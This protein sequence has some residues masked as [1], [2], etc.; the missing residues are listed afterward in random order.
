AGQSEAVMA[1]ALGIRLGGPAVY[2]GRPVLKP[3]IGDDTMSPEPGHID[4]A[5]R[6]AV[7][8][9]AL[10]VLLVVAVIFLGGALFN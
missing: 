6:L 5:N 4:Q 3:V 7:V 9:T 10:M 1:G 2:F 8:T